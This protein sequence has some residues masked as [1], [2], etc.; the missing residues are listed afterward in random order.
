[1]AAALDSSR[2]ARRCNSLIV[3]GG[4][5][6][7]AA[8][9]YLAQAGVDVLLVDRYDLNT[10]A[11]GR[12][13]GGFHVQIQ[14]EPFETEGEDWARAW[15][16]TIPLLIEAVEVWQ[17][18][19]AELGVDLEVKLTGGLL[20]AETDGQ[21]RAVEQ[22]AAIE[23][24]AGLEVELL[25]RDDL[26]RV[27][28]Y[29]SHS[30]AGGLLCPLEGK[31]NPLLATPAFGRAAQAHGARLELGV[32][33]LAIE[34]T[35]SGFHV[36]TSAGPVECERIIDCAGTAAGR[37]SELVGVPLPVESHPLQAHVTEPVAPL[38][39]HLVYFAGELLTIKQAAVGSVLIGGGW[40]ADVD[41]QTGRLAVSEAS[42]RSNLRVAQH[43]I[44]ALAQARLLRI[45]TGAC[46]GT[47]DHRPI[48]GE[49]DDVPGFFV[50]V[51]PFLGFTAAP[52]M[53]KLVADL[54]LGRPSSHDLGP[55]VAAR[56]AAATV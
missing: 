34:R 55:F 30:M 27:A 9:Y 41:E 56:F 2:T 26:R 29:I 13:A 31:A 18:L 40:P 5:T 37:I 44:P 17:G 20:A 52:L 53:G 21:M 16:P 4:L 3:G 22:K 35:A 24:S 7:C 38:V 42:L 46:N 51:F 47:P 45:W 49:L 36:E 23:R 1:V 14:F 50:A 8:A 39:Q 12:N 54:A 28:P 10:E 33:V 15:A 6:G 32:E 25:S 48:L 19:S 11:S 43:V